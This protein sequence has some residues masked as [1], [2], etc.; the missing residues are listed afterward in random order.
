MEEDRLAAEHR[1]LVSAER[2]QPMGDE[3]VERLKGLRARERKVETV[4]PPGAVRKL[5]LMLLHILTKSNPLCW[6][7]IS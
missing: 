5:G 1:V 3:V 6:A 4:E 2:T 7:W